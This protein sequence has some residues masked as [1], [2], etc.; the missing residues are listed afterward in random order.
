MQ[1]LFRFLNI[2]RGFPHRT[3]KSVFCGEPQPSGAGNLSKEDTLKKILAIAAMM[4]A[5]STPALAQS[6]DLWPPA[7][8]VEID[9]AKCLRPDVGATHAWC[10]RVGRVAVKACYA[11]GSISGK[12]VCSRQVIVRIYPQ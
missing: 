8:T 3:L 7:M 6:A 5:L 2:A 4:A 10:P 12:L 11:P 9:G 1:A